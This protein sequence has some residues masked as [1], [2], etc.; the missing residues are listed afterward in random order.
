MP[1]I[2][3]AGFFIPISLIPVWLRWAQYLCALKYGVNI[4]LVIEFSALPPVWPE[5][6]PESLYYLVGAP[7]LVQTRSRGSCC[8]WKRVVIHPPPPPHTHT[9]TA[10]RNRSDGTCGCIYPRTCVYVHMHARLH[11]VQQAVYGCSEP[12]SDCEGRVDTALFPRN[13]IDTSLLWMYIII[14]GGIFLLFR[15]LAAILLSARSTT[16]T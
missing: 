13:E 4:L 7:S 12:V 11:F 1:Q 2:L 6:V 16:F 9:L 8:G 14:M 10:V 5:D 3:F 15:V